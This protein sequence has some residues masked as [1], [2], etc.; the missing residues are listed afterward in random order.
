MKRISLLALAACLALVIASPALAGY[1]YDIVNP[2]NSSAQINLRTDTDSIGCYVPVAD[3]THLRPAYVPCSQFAAVG[4]QS[5]TGTTTFGSTVTVAGVF[6][7]NNK[8]VLTW[9]PTPNDGITD[10]AL[11][12]ALTAPIDTSGTQTHDGLAI[13][14]TVSNAT[15]GTNTVNGIDF[16]NYTGD[17]QVNVTALNIGTSDGLGTSTGLKIGTGWTAGISNASPF[18]QTGNLTAS[19]GTVDISP[20]YSATA[21]GNPV[22][23]VTYGTCTVAAVNAGTCTIITGVASRVLE[24]TNFDIIATGS[25]ATCTGVLLEDTNGTPV[26]AS[27]LA[28]ATLTNG[29][30]NVPLTATLGVGFGA[31]SGLTSGASLQLKVNGSGCTTTTAFGY[32]VAYAIH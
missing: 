25:A 15:G 19:T 2:E 3:T 13:D 7:V 26:V 10:K 29:A 5:F 24:V 6:S 18:T 1:N 32:M 8:S 28:A 11:D 16:T 30:H 31:G 14:L 4:S 23:K 27:T 9:A 17:A 12:I 21:L 22:V 20:A